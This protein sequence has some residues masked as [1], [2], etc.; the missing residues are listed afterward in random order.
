M[1]LMDKMKDG[2]KSMDDKLGTVVDG[3]KAEIDVAKEENKIK[4]ATKSIGEQVVKLMDDGKAFDDPEIS[5]L[6]EDIKAS[7]ARIADLKKQQED[8]KAKL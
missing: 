2:L 3:G 1:G 8:Y 6:F 4:E 7:R 5:R